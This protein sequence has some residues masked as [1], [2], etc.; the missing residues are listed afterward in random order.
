MALNPKEYV[1]PIS[2][3]LFRE[4]TERQEIQIR[5][6]VNR[7]YDEGGSQH[8]FICAGRTV[9]LLDEKELRSYFPRPVVQKLHDEAHTLV[10]AIDRLHRDRRKFEQAFGSVLRRCHTMQDI[11]DLLPDTLVASISPLNNMTRTR[12]M[13]FLIQDNAFLKAPFEGLQDVISYYIANRLIY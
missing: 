11:R 12:D 5:D 1:D 10:K 9:S 2:R 8:A 4:E 3:T 13:A 6:L 7:N